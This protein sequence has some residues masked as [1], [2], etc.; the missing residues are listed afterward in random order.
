MLEGFVIVLREGMEAFLIVGLCV[1]YLRKTG[2]HHLESAVHWGIAF[3]VVICTVAGIMLYQ[4]TFNQAFWEGLF[5]LVAAV[6]VGTL[7]VHM[8]RSARSIKRE[9][10]SQLENASSKS[11]GAGAYLAVFLFTVLMIS[12]EGIETALLLGSLMFQTA[13]RL[14][15]FGCVLGLVAAVVMALLWTR[16]GHR[17]NLSRFFQVTAV[18]LLI[19]VAQLIVY[20]FHE[21]AEASLFPNSDYLHEITEPYGPDGRYG[22]FLT[23]SLVLIP[24]AWLLLSSWVKSR[25]PLAEK[26]IGKSLKSG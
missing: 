9:I 11:D 22:R 2:R 5:S 8:W 14:I 24:T 7:T 15:L 10:E 26:T 1:A 17:V 6:F 13:T 21:M 19:F 16:F 20:S 23:Y 25:S 3:S 12:R 18:F 4:V